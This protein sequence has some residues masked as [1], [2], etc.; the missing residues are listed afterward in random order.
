M[1]AIWKKVISYIN[2]LF[3][4][5]VLNL[6]NYFRLWRICIDHVFIHFPHPILFF[7]NH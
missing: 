2:Y 7:P 5:V 1:L 4:D 6:F 3:S